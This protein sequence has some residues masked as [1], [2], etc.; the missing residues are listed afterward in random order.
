MAMLDMRE[1][2]EFITALPLLIDH[3]TRENVRLGAIEV[4]REREGAARVAGLEAFEAGASLDDGPATFGDDGF[5]GDCW[6]TGWRIGEAKTLRAKLVAAERSRDEARGK[7]AEVE[8]IITAFLERA[9]AK[10]IGG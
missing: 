2:V 6:I 7:L 9:G 4:A 8:R 10:P 1:F 5:L 3:L